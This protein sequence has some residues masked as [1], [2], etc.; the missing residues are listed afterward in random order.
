MTKRSVIVIANVYYVLTICLS[1]TVQVL[2]YLWS[3]LVYEIGAIVL[4]LQKIKL[5]LW[6]IRKLCFLKYQLPP[7]F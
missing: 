2:S 7:K 5:T 6:K 1:L 3:Q 4:I